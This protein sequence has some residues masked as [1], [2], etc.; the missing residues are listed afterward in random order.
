MAEVADRNDA[1]MDPVALVEYTYMM[2]VMRNLCGNLLCLP[3]G[4]LRD[5]KNE[6]LGISNEPVHDQM[7]NSI[8]V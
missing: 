5:V 8:K 3:V 1:S 7:S 2:V 4:M 6:W